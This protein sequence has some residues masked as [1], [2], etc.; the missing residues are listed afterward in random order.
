V[1]RLTADAGS[2]EAIDAARDEIAAIWAERDDLADRVGRGE[3][4][5]T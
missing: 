3:V 5:A 2:G 1:E 4:S